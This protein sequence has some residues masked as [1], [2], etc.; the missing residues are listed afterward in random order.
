MLNIG[1]SETGFQHMVALYCCLWIWLPSPSLG[2][3]MTSKIQLWV[4]LPGSCFWNA[5]SIFYREEWCHPLEQWFS[6]TYW[7]TASLLSVQ[8]PVSSNTYCWH[9]RL[10]LVDQR[11]TRSSSKPPFCISE[12]SQGTPFYEWK[13]L[14]RKLLSRSE[15]VQGL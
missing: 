15:I 8:L 11:T 12:I 2:P 9:I 10:E 5:L 14:W 6:T 1:W 13:I 3:T 7:A 4:D